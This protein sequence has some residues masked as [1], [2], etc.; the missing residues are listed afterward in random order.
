[1]ADLDGLHIVIVPAWWPAPE[2]PMR[3]IFN[4]DYVEAFV[5]AGAKVGVIV[6]DLVSL[7]FLGEAERVPILPR[8][9]FEE[10]CGAPVVRIRAWH[11]ALGVPGLQMNRF[12][13]WLV[14]GLHAYAERYGMPHAYHAMCALPAGWACASLPASLA[15]PVVL[16]EHTGPFSLVLGAKQG[17]PYM[18][19]AF[20]SAAAAVAVSELS[21]SQMIEAGVRREIL[22]C[23]NPIATCFTAPVIEDRPPSSPVRALFLGRLCIEKGVKELLDA[24]KSMIGIEWHFAGDGPLL[25]EAKAALPD[26]PSGPRAVFHGFVERPALANLIAQS[27]LLVL[28]SHGEIFGMAV[29]EALCMGLPVLTTDATACSDF[30]GPEDGVV[31][32]AKDSAALNTGVKGLLAQ[33]P[34]FSRQSIARRARSRLSADAVASCYGAILRSAISHR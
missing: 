6:P 13:R 29:A 31:V 27:D 11:T 3:G 21:R 25:A 23:P 10:C 14:R 32:R 8:V 17:E 22:V 24:A 34:R 5:A 19:E 4:A 28:P 30:V 18:R 16:T 9:D 26:N 12:R 15:R 2:S 20:E 33:F 7:R 1:M